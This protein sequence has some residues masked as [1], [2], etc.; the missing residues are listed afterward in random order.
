MR[1][2]Q[3]L[4]AILL[5]VCGLLALPAWAAVTSTVTGQVVD[6]DGMPL[7]GVTVSAMGVSATTDAGGMYSLAGVT[8]AERVLVNFSLDGYAPNQGVVALLR[9]VPAVADDECDEDKKHHKQKDKH[10]KKYKKEKHCRKHERNHG[11]K[12]KGQC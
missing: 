6:V 12:D 8:A 4:R 2:K 10:D 9:E 1:N 7:A 3:W 5:G 11:R